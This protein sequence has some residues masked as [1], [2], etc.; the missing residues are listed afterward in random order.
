MDFDQYIQISTDAQPK[1]ARSVALTGLASRR[2][3][4]LDSPDLTL[5]QVSTIIKEHYQ[6]ADGKIELF[7]NITGY[8]WMVLEDMQKSISKVF[9]IEGNFIKDSIVFD[10]L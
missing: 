3:I 6:Q 2:K 4:Q 1:G 8:S 5:D 7:G 9:D 10:E